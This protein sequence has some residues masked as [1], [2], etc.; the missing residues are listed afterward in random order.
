[1]SNIVYVIQMNY[2]GEE[3]INQSARVGCFSTIEKTIAG[4]R[5]YLQDF[6]QEGGMDE[7]YFTGTQAII[8]GPTYP[9]EW[10]ND[11]AVKNMCSEFRK[12]EKEFPEIED[13]LHLGDK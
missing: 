2:Q 11:Q 10:C 13:R 3:Y 9:I 1:M 6:R 5:K 7:V 4:V 12:I 8:D